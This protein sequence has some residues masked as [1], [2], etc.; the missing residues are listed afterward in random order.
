MLKS[1]MKRLDYVIYENKIC[2]LNKVGDLKSS[3]VGINIFDDG[4]CYFVLEF[5]APNHKIKECTVAISERSIIYRLREWLKNHKNAFN[6]LEH[7]MTY[8]HQFR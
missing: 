4:D 6:F 1:R 5:D 3:I 8:I 7:E 2:I